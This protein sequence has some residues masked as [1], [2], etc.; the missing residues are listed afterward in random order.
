LSERLAWFNGLPRDEA[1]M[2]LHECCGSS[3]WASTVAGRRPYAD[4]PALVWAADDV[5]TALAPSDWL[6]AFAAHPRIGESGGQAPDTSQKEQSRIM[7][8]GDETLAL[9]GEENRRY[10]A[11]FG[12]VFV[13]SASGR[14]AA[15]VLAALRERMKN[16]PAKEVAVAAEEQRKITRLRMERMLQG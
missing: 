4:V 12:H 15:E 13:I 8:E 5:W 9:L 3:A 2:Y 16:D 10:E 11:Q 1:E 14:S 6:E 7:G